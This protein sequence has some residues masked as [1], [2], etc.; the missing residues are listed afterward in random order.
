MKICLLTQNLY[1]LGGIQR[2]VATILPELIADGGYEV[3]VLM[4]FAEEGQ[5]LFQIPK[6]VELKDARTMRKMPCSL[7][8]YILAANKRLGF[9]N[10]PVL[11]QLVKR[12]KFP[13]ETLRRY[14]DFLNE[15]NF[16]VVIGTNSEYSMLVGA[17]SDRISA[18]T[19]GWQ[20]STFESY[21]NRRGTN[22]FG[23]T[24]YAKLCYRKLD[25]VWVLTNADKQ[26][27]DRAFGID[28]R[29]LYD[30]IPVREPESAPSVS[31][32]TEVIFVGRLNRDIKGL[33][34]L[35]E[36]VGR[37]Q[38]QLPEMRVTVVG[39]GRDRTWMESEIRKANPPINI[40]LVGATDD[41]YTYYNRAALML[42]TSRQEGFGMAIVEAMSCGVPTVA[43]HNLGPDE[44][45]R[46]GVDGYLIDRFDVNLFVQKAVELLT[47]SEKLEAFSIEAKKRAKAFETSTLM[48]VFKEYLNDAVNR[49]K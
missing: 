2:V 25:S 17:L 15:G 12:M 40:D 9:L 14:A 24:Q 5:K 10:H 46:D 19:V 8:R 38:K 33:D 32:R 35:I 39:D 31:Q 22:S 7:M 4:P 45:I 20:H 11:N 42:Q 49:Q 44:V 34:Y 41:V 23:L 18:R 36:I 27:F 21:F 29:V 1:S 30:P 13:E 6:E 3:S 16:D 43:F 26:M 28:S 37:M 47:D 48:P